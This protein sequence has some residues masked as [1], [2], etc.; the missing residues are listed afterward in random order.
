M[1]H[2]SNRVDP[3]SFQRGFVDLCNQK[4][5]TLSFQNACSTLYTHFVYICVFI[6]ESLMFCHF[7]INSQ[8]K[9]KITWFLFMYANVAL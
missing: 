4:N 7:Q 2:M 5:K 8:E 6:S 9:V 3:T 1:P